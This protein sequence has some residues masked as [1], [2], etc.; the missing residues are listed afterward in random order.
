MP[1]CFMNTHFNEDNMIF[2]EQYTKYWARSVN[3]SVDGTVI[4]GVNE[5]KYFVQDLKI[6]KNDRVLDLGCSFGRLY[7]V[8]SSYSDQVYGAD[9]DS[10][11]VNEARLKPYIDVL[12]GTAETT[13]FGRS[14][15][16]TVVCWAVFDVVDHAKGLEEITRILKPGGKLLFT[17]K[18]DNYYM[19]DLLAFK[20]EK[21]AFLKN[22]PN[23]FTDLPKLLRRFISMGLQLDRLVI[24]PRRGDMGL[25]NWSNSTHDLI[26]YIG[27]EYLIICHKITPQ[28]GYD[29]SND[30]LDEKFSKTAYKMAIENGYTST[31]EFFESIGLD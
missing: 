10:F 31:H 29:I 17:G 19:D 1:G 3:K 30:D 14:F 4:A 8:L 24:F 16:D 6:K 28:D 23:R 11:A 18:N 27:C 15:F 22:F 25:L 26:D 21:N 7:E 2:D 5:A 13:G 12:Q 20:A 9:P